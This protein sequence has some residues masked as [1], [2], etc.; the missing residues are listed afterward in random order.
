MIA[1]KCL[2]VIP[3][4]LLSTSSV[5]AEE[6]SPTTTIFEVPSVYG[7]STLQIDSERRLLVVCHEGK[8]VGNGTA[9]IENVGG[10]NM[11]V[12]KCEWIPTKGKP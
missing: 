10:Q 2:A 7:N 6:Q 4:L 12:A 3:V 11:L 9:D 8:R 1:M 5:L